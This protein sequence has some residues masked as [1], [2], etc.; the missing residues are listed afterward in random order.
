LRAIIRRSK[1]DPFGMAVSGSARGDRETDRR[2]ARLAWA[3][4][5]STVLRDIPGQADQP[6]FR[7]DQG[8]ADHKGS[9]DRSRR[10]ARRCGRVQR[11][12]TVRRC[13]PGLALRRHSIMLLSYVPADGSRFTCLAATWSLPSTMSGHENARLLHRLTR[14]AE[15]GVAQTQRNTLPHSGL[16]GLLNEIAFQQPGDRCWRGCPL[17]RRR[18]GWRLLADHP[19]W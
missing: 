12:L 2:V 19:A 10:A 18:Q 15:I 13:G 3:G 6:T 4:N 1:S 7:H 16:V 9:C 17:P 8:Q 14:I 11:A 5:R